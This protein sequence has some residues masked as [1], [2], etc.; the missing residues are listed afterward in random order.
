MSTRASALTFLERA[1]HETSSLHSELEGVI[2]LEQ[3]CASEASYRQVLRT[4]YGIW[5]PLEALLA[6]SP[7]TG[8]SSL[9]LKNRMRMEQLHHDLLILGDSPEA[10]RCLPTADLPWSTLSKAEAAGVLYVMEGSTH[11]GKVIGK[12]LESRLGITS[13]TGSRFF[14]GH[15]ERNM[16]LWKGFVQWTASAL[17]EDE[18]PPAAEASRQTFQSLINWFRSQLPAEPHSA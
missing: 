8:D 11:G 18:I 12:T 6:D 17:E 3:I 5:A 16:E 10:I 1:R 4:F 15:G 2:G 13:Q 7:L 9:E 14:A